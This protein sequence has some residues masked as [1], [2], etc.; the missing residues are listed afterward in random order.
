MNTAEE[1]V[2][3]VLM[4]LVKTLNTAIRDF[5][6]YFVCSLTTLFIS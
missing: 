3:C 4:D 1:C 5:C 6:L 2:L